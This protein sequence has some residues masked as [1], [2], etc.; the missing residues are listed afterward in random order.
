MGWS[1]RIKGAD[2]MATRPRPYYAHTQAELDWYLK[3]YGP[4]DKYDIT[5][6][7]DPLSPGERAELERRTL[8]TLARE[9]ARSD[10]V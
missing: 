10:T 6:A 1:I 2:Q 3:Q 7:P 8:A 5:R 9:K 4:A